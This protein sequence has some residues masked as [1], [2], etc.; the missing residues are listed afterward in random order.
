MAA[1]AQQPLII[2]QHKDWNEAILRYGLSNTG[3]VVHIPSDFK[4]RATAIP[5]TPQ[6]TQA[7][8][9]LSSAKQRSGLGLSLI[10]TQLARHF[11]LLIVGMTV[12]GNLPIYS[13]LDKTHQDLS[14]LNLPILS[15]DDAEL[16]DLNLPAI[17]LE[18]YSTNTTQI[19]N[20]SQNWQ[21]VKVAETDSLESLLAKA[22]Q[23]SAI[24]KIFE[25]PEIKSELTSLTPTADIA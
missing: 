21:V 2:R 9:S 7:L 5:S 22:K 23:I 4:P 8:V 25:N 16:K 24:G 19:P 13:K 18:S 11:L 3:I 20:H 15:P 6:A 14:T 17:S 12:L 1:L 10:L